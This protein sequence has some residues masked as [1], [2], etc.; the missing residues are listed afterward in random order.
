MEDEISGAAVIQRL[1]PIHCA[2]HRVYKRD[3]RWLA[4][5]KERVRSDVVRA[6]PQSVDRIL[7][8]Q[9]RQG[10]VRFL[11]EVGRELRLEQRRER[12]ERKVI[13][14]RRAD[15]GEGEEG[16]VAVL[17]GEDGPYYP[18]V[19][20]AVLVQRGAMGVNVSIT[21]EFLCIARG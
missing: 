1:H 13:R 3:S 15:L 10:A 11:R 21:I 16:E 6:N 18:A 5:R 7:W 19:V 9:L 12:A 4:A 8:F 17:G 14:A 20:V 2:S